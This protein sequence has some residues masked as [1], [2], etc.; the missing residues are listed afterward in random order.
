M[1]RK[2]KII[3]TYGGAKKSAADMTAEEFNEAA[4]KS[5]ERVRYNAFSHGLPIYYGMNG[6]IIAEYAD[7]R[8]EIVKD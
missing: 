4:K 2:I 3:E 1:G 6:K 5:M 7:G 8:K